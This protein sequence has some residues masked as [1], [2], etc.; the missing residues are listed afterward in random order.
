MLSNKYRLILIAIFVG[1]I[2]VGGLAFTFVQ[3]CLP[4]QSE[5]DCAEGGILGRGSTTLEVWGVFDN[6]AAYSQM[7]G[8]FQAINPDVNFIYRKIDVETYEQELLSALATNRGPDIFQ[9]HSSRINQNQVHL[10]PVTNLTQ[11]LFGISNTQLMNNYVDVVAPDMLRGLSLYAIPFSVD[12]L[13]LYYND[14]IFFNNILSSPPPTWTDFLAYV[15]K[16]ADVNLENGSIVRPAAAIGTARNINRSTDILMALMFQSGVD[17]YD[18]T[19]QNVILDKSPGAENSL[20]FYTDFTSPRKKVYTWNTAQ[21]F[22]TDG[23][24]RGDVAMIFNYSYLRP[25]LTRINPALQYS[26]AP[27]PQIS[28]PDNPVSYANYW[29][30]GVSANSDSPAKAWE[31]LLFAQQKD[32]VQSY[33]NATG[34][35]PAR[36]DLA[37]EIAQNPNHFNHVFAKQALFAKTWFQNNPDENERILANMIESVVI[38]TRTIE[39]ALEEASFEM[40]KVLRN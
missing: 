12:T 1:V 7:F 34:R 19:F 32:I 39:E 26:I 27:L 33:L 16:L 40:S 18:Q 5:E 36:K 15:E 11:N 4:W 29:A 8:Q 9:V 20:K 37:F 21:D 13:A 17:I 31:F 10:V 24:A 2:A 30:Y 28:N 3:D 25:T 23:F 22:S 35:P 6:Q 14:T 38:G